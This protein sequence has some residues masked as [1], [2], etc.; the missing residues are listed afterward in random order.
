M[1]SANASARG[2]R[3]SRAL[4]DPLHWLG[5]LSLAFVL[6][7]FIAP[8]FLLLLRSVGFPE[9]QLDEFAVVFR[10]AGYVRV[11]LAT[12]WIAL[13][14]TLITF[15][16]GYPL[17]WLIVTAPSRLLR[18]S[19]L[20]AII[21]SQ[22]ISV[23]IRSF[24]WQVIL[25][26]TGPLA[27]WMSALTGARAQGLLFTKAGTVIGLVHYMLPFMVL[28]LVTVMQRT[29]WS[30]VRSAQTLGAGPAVRFFRVFAPLTIAGIAVGTTVIF[31][32]SLGSF[33]APAILGGR[34]GTMIGV[35]IASALN[36]L[37][38]YGVAAVLSL[39]VMA[40]ALLSAL[41]Y[42][43]LL[44]GR[45]EW[46]INPEHIELRPPP[47]ARAPRAWSALAAGAGGLF[48][49]AVL[50]LDTAGISRWRWPRY[51]FVAASLLFILGPEIVTIAISFSG[52]RS[53]IFPPESWSLRWF[54]AFFSPRWLQPTWV[55][56]Q[57]ALLASTLAVLVGGSAAICVARSS[58]AWMRRVLPVL[59]LLPLLIPGVV[60]AS[61]YYV[62]LLGLHLNDTVLGIA[63]A[64][65]CLL[66]P[67]AFSVMLANLR[68]IAIDPEQIAQSL[69]ARPLTVIGRILLPQMR[70]G[71]AVAFLLCA[72]VSFG[73][74]VASIFLSGVH[75]QTLPAHMFAAVSKGSDPTVAVPGTLM[76]ALALLCWLFFRFQRGWKTTG[77]PG[78]PRQQVKIRA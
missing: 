52:P 64:H 35:A 25:G 18:Q 56:V 17:A 21:S 32:Y 53:L 28:L 46:L 12:L 30:I 74:D 1:K 69:G 76:L 43:V 37:G 51:L 70:S 27:S 5:G 8:V 15:A 72:I 23:L 54:A 39:L 24:A 20:I 50:A 33:A 55:S 73:E 3:L 78:L 11:L 7:F 68:A 42:R 4:R 38:D 75:T 71:V 61:A 16:V 62:V 47:G 19:L 66:L 10:G 48:N 2:Q 14:T 57:V 45:L 41:V 13:L 36:E 44:A 31:I 58:S 49:R 60:T 59:R 9:F 22:L 6:L 40:A 67:F 63:L 34:R 26:S 65:T 29:N 77:A